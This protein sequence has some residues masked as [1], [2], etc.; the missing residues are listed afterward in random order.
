MTSAALVFSTSDGKGQIRGINSTN[1]RMNL[2]SLS[3][4]GHQENQKLNSDKLWMRDR[5]KDAERK[6]ENHQFLDADETVE[7]KMLQSRLVS[8]TFVL[9][10][11]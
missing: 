1:S 11:N 6:I 10:S 3:K 7:N 9:V 8:F 2:K 4:N 5:N